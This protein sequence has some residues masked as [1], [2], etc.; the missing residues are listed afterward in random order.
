MEGEMCG[1]G[2]GNEGMGRGLMPA[3]LEAGQ[4]WERGGGEG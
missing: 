1:G 3:V 2:S 4:A